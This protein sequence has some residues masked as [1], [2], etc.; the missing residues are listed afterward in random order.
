[1]SAVDESKQEPVVVFIFRR[2]FRLF[3]NTTFIHTAKRCHERK[4]K[5][6]PIFIF[7][8][9]QME[10][11]NN[12]YYNHRSV[13]F[14]T[15]SLKGLAFDIR[16]RQG[17]MYTLKTKHSDIDVLR[18][19]EGLVCLKGVSCNMD[20]TPYAVK[21]D[22]GIKRWCQQRDIEYIS[23]EDYTMLPLDKVKTGQG[24]CFDKFIPFYRKAVHM[25]VPEPVEVP[26]YV[27]GEDAFAIVDVL[28]VQE[29]E[30][31]QTNRQKALGILE[32]IR[33][34]CCRSYKKQHCIPTKDLGISTLHAYIRYGC[35]SIREV[36]DTCKTS[37]GRASLIVEHLFAREHAYVLA[38][39]YPNDVLHGQTSPD[40]R[41]Y[42]IHR[43]YEK[44]AD[45]WN[46][47]DE[48]FDSWCQGKTG[49]PLI[50]A[51]MKCL[52]ATGWINDRLRMI[53]ALFLV[54]DLNID[55]RKGERF[56]ASQ[57]LDYDPAINHQLWC[58]TLTQKRKLNPYKMLGKYD[59][60]ALFTRQ[61]LPDLEPV[62]VLDIVTWF[63][64]HSKYPHICQPMRNVQGYRVKYKLYIPGYVRPKDPNYVKR[65][66]TSKYA[67][68]VKN[69]NKYN[70]ETRQQMKKTKNISRGESCR[71]NV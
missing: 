46:T 31:H 67:G 56:F 14:M 42:C 41:N 50:D 48:D 57:L 21:R 35:I 69:V 52:L 36:Y 54:A 12:A 45:K 60:Q 38:H 37:C 19:L 32:N 25:K 51:S 11:S 58:W 65:K 39:C 8:D 15:E 70:K 2:D 59:P 66:K 9:T 4:W 40:Q 22:A 1:M 24:A 13:E 27:F 49:L 3:D 7:N 26:D 5:I 30:H 62:P 43:R 64:T 6:L 18:L 29:A 71:D 17:E 47:N 33:K 44:S 16:Q 63:Q 55:W 23:C 20:V 68:G 61:W 34:G 53:L 10:A 28:K